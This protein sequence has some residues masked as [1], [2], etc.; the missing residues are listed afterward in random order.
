MSSFKNDAEIEMKSMRKE[1]S[2]IQGTA[3][4]GDKPKPRVHFDSVPSI[5][6]I[7]S[8]RELLDAEMESTYRKIKAEEARR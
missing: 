6:Q 8:R 3:A 1:N 4:A 7:P 2:G 5:R